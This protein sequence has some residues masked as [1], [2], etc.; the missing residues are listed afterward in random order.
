MYVDVP[1]F[2][3]LVAA[4]P[5]TVKG[6]DHFILE[7]KKFYGVV[8]VQVYVD[9]SQVLLARAEES[10]PGEPGHDDLDCQERLKLGL[11]SHRIHDRQRG[12]QRCL[13]TGIGWTR[14]QAFDQL[15]QDHLNELVRHGI[16]EC[17]P[18]ALSMA[19]QI[20]RRCQALVM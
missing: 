14:S 11:R 9:L 20:G 5:I 17:F 3:R 4:S 12:V 2:D 7:S 19:L 15:P 10:K 6:L 8:S 18:Q 1:H 16:A 13:L